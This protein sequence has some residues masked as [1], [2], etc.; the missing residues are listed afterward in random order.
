MNVCKE[1]ERERQRA[2]EEARERERERERGIFCVGLCR[3][4]VRVFLSTHACVCVYLFVCL[5]V[6]VYVFGRVCACAW[7]SVYVCM[8]VCVCDP[9]LKSNLACCH[10]RFPHVHPPC[11]V[12]SPLIVPA[13]LLRSTPA[14]PLSSFLPPSLP[15]FL[16][17][18]LSLFSLPLLLPLSVPPS[19]WLSSTWLTRQRRAS[20]T[21]AWRGRSRSSVGTLHAA[22][23]ATA[24]RIPISKECQKRPLHM[25]RELFTWKERH[26]LIIT[27]VDVH[28]MSK[29]TS[30]N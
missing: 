4:T 6:C 18:F 14:P 23:A 20:R 10:L 24:S 13:S 9:A 3:G 19:L 5:L 15:L 8:C 17:P 12:V 26:V 30:V 27:Y 28:R 21:S 7:E 2:K 25:K 16:R 11:G 29:E 22:P 1:R